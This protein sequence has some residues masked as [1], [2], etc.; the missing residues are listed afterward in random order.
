[1]FGIAF[2]I[3]GVVRKSGVP[4]EAAL[5]VFSKIKEHNQRNPD[6]AIP[7]I[8]VT[9]GGGVTEQQYASTFCIHRNLNLRCIAI[10]SQS[11]GLTINEE[12]MLLSHTP[13]RS[14]AV[15]Y[16]D[17]PVLVVGTA[18]YSLP[19]LYGFHRFV[20]WLRAMLVTLQSCHGIRPC[21]KTPA[22]CTNWLTCSSHN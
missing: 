3:D 6:H 22:A 16:A 15:R 17:K 1:M 19:H 4:L 2:D 11:L 7:F 21:C 5:R 20:H 10:L 8:F 9:N 13:M 12:Q 18:D 14:L